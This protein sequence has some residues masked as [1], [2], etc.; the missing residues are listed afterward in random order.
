MS[1]KDIRRSE[2]WGRRKDEVDGGVN[3]QSQGAVRFGSRSG[4]I[5]AYLLVLRPTY[6]KGEKNPS[7]EELRP[8]KGYR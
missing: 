1:T 2:R 4:Q 3:L 7:T 5:R 6:Q 8:A